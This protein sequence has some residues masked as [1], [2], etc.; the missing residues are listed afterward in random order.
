MVKILIKGKENE[1]HLLQG[2]EA[3]VSAKREAEFIDFKI[4]ETSYQEKGKK[5]KECTLSFNFYKKNELIKIETNPIQV[6]VPQEISS[7]ENSSKAIENG[8][9]LM[10]LWSKESKMLKWKTSQKTKFESCLNNL[11]ENRI[12]ELNF[13][14]IFFDIYANF[15]LTNFFKNAQNY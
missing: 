13:S 2:N 6:F 14:S 4:L 3:I 1:P 7:L 11:L 12:K 9:D 10:N 15:C 8:T 5:Y